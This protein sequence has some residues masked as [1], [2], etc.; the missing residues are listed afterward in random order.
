MERALRSV[1]IGDL[2]GDGRADIV[3]YDTTGV[4]VLVQGGARSHYPV[5]SVRALEL[6]PL[7]GEPGL[8][9]VIATTS[10]FTTLRV[11]SGIAPIAT[12][13][14][15]DDERLYAVD[16]DRDGSMDLVGFTRGGAIHVYFG[17]GSGRFPRTQTIKLRDEWVAETIAVGELFPGQTELVFFVRW[18]YAVILGRDASGQWDGTRGTQIGSPGAAFEEMK[19]GELSGDG[20]TDVMFVGQRL[21]GFGLR[22]LTQSPSLNFARMSFGPAA[23]PKLTWTAA[24]ADFDRNRHSDIAVLEQ[25][26]VDDKGVRVSIFLQSA[27]RFTAGPVADLGL[28]ST[29]SLVAGDVDCDGCVDLIANGD[30][31]LRGRCSP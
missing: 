12:T 26:S 17:D 27:G 9:V 2:D 18:G 15:V 24:L 16:A 3:G 4:W 19:L 25:N 23:V 6:L 31:L 10:S 21:W 29:P 11:G 22:I 13:A 20:L 14:A 1:R 7:S 8:G 30:Q 5:S 28:T